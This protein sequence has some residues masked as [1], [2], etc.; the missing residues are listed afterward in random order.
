MALLPSTQ[1]DQIMLTIC[2]A[3]L[4]LVYVYYE[5]AHTPKAELLDTLQT[6][7][8]KLE[9]GNETV[10]QEVARGTATK[11]KE[12]AD[13]YGRLLLQMRQFVPVSN[14]VPT[15]LDQVSNAARQTG[16]ELGEITPMGVIPGEVFDTYKYRM[17]VTGPYNRIGQFLSNVGSLTRIIAPMNLSLQ[18]SNRR[19]SVRKGEQILDA[20]FDIQTFVVKVAPPVISPPA[21]TGQ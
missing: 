16:L 15:L 13:M 2:V 1:R 3:F 7:I 19:A 11:L 9:A 8:E 21:G 12:E 4:A 20:G 17:G 18:P 14:E 6:R 5:Y 10:R